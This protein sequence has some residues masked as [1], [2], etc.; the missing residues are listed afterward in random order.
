MAVWPNPVLGNT[1]YRF[2]K[3]QDS[4]G[5][6]EFQNQVQRLCKALHLVLEFI[7]RRFWLMRRKIVSLACFR[8][9]LESLAR[10]AVNVPARIAG[11]DSTC[12]SP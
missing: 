3:Y 6:D 8:S 9:S 4:Q 12:P 10:A 11:M 1:D 7:R 2:A 5:R